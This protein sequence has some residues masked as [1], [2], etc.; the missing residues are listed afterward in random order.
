MG[1]WGTVEDTVRGLRLT[2]G[3]RGWVTEVQM[4]Q[5]ELHNYVMENVRW[6]LEHGLDDGLED[7]LPLPLMDSFGDCF[8]P[9]DQP[10]AL[11][12]LDGLELQIIPSASP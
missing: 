4:T 12:R 10:Y 3:E 1:Q 7:G 8:G 5:A 11:L 2:W 9:Q 6:R